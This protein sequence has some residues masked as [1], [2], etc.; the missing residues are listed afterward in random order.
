MPRI[1]YLTGVGFMA[2]TALTVAQAPVQPPGAPG[3]APA[4]E[5]A[6]PQSVSAQ[7]PEVTF[8]VEVNYVEEDV[9]VIDR[10]GNFVRGLKREDFQ[11]MEDGKPQK[12]NTFGMA[13]IPVIP[14]RRPA[15]M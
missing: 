10:T 4:Q 5:I 15:F 12:I 8:R 6:Q 7:A 11:L 1:S 3:A 14:I 9:R 13:D 2:A